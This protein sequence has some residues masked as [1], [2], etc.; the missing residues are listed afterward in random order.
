MSLGFLSAVF[1][2]G[3]LLIAPN[4]FLMVFLPHLPLTRR[5]MQSPWSV[6][7]PALLTIGFGLTFLFSDNLLLP[8]FGNL[9]LSAAS[10]SGFEIYLRVIQDWAP[11]AL[12]MWLHAVAADVVMARWAY[13]ESQN[14]RLPTVSVSVAIL[15][16][17]TN[18]PLGFL[19]YVLIRQV[20]MRG[21]PPRITV[22][23]E[24]KQ[25]THEREEGVKKMSHTYSDCYFCG[26]EVEEKLLPREIWHDGRLFIIEGV[27]TG[28]CTQCGEKFIHASV[29]KSLDK[30]LAGNSAP[31]KTIHVPVYAFT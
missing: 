8:Q 22:A 31:R 20:T 11:A 26:G 29:A 17:G 9:L 1:I 2:V 4:Y 7:A 13:L 12:V 6:A 15:L 10:S 21:R 14:L 5:V 18:G 16:M 23:H 27:P 30:I 19:V 28:V 25:A 24:T 3:N